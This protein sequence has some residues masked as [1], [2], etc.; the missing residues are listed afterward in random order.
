MYST[1]CNRQKCQTKHNPQ[2][3]PHN[4]LTEAQKKTPA[5]RLPN[6]EIHTLEKTNSI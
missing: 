4:Q 6:L 1:A 2:Q 3:A 5:L